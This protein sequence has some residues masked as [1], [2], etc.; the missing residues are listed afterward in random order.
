MPTLV[1][2]GTSY[3]LICRRFKCLACGTLAETSKTHPREFA[4]CDCGEVS[5]DGGIG[6]GATVNGTPSRME[7]CS[8]YRAEDGT[9]H[10]IRMDVK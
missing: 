5:I 3:T 10:Q 9:L 2:N 8:L 4:A 1:H 7:D 6:V